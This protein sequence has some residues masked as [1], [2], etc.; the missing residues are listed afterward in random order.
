[1][2][3]GDTSMRYGAERSPAI[4]CLAIGR[5]RGIRSASASPTGHWDERTWPPSGSDRELFAPSLERQTL[6]G[7]H[8]RKR[9]VLRILVDEDRVKVCSKGGNQ[10]IAQ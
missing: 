2:F 10:G 1:M 8:G 5:R 6:L 9:V 7:D 4:A 3:A